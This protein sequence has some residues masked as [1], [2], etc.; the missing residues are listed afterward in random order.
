M[1]KSANQFLKLLLLIIF[2][3]ANVFAQFNSYGVK[4]GLQFNLLAPSNEFPLTKY[5]LNFSYLARGFI[6]FELSENFDA[7]AGLGYGL[8]S[9]DDYTGAHYNTTIIPLDV[10]LLYSP[11]NLDNW[12]PYLFGGLG[13]I[14]FS[15]DDKPVSPTIDPTEDSGLSGLIPV[16]IGTEVK[17]N[18]DMALDISAGYS[19]SFTDNL[20]FVNQAEFNDGYWHLGFGITFGGDNLDSDSD[21]DGLT[22]REEIEIGTN[23]EIADTDGDGLID[24]DE[25]RKHQTNPN[26]I[27]SDIDGLNDGEEVK[28]H[29]TNP[30]NADSD[31]DGLN[32]FDEV[33]KYTTNPNNPD[34][35]TDGLRD[36]DEVNN[37]KTKELKADSDSDGLTDGEEV[38]KYKTD[39]LNPDTDGGS[40]NDGEEIKR[41]TNPNDISDDVEVNNI[42]EQVYYENVYFSFD[43]H[44]LTNSAKEILDNVVKI[45]N[46]QLKITINLSA[47]TDNIGNE[48]Y[49]IK[50]SEKRAKT[51][52]KYLVENGLNESSIFYEFFGESKPEVENSSKQNRNKNRRVE[53]KITGIKK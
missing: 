49:N 24:G 29:Q 14:H 40:V 32:D 3:S 35:D 6:R 11:F 17:I 20:N 30:N 33:N 43:K 53:I 28:V 1:K 47:H 4:G 27:D 7:E 15:V 45:S 13:L 39:P 48:N 10:R 18:D 41:G 42:E 19:Y 22:K 50:L 9:G 36:G 51:V 37:Y 52:K 26:N 2:L 12:N 5:D 44:S 34:T 31:N 8:Y 46:N 16:G 38:N 25:F 21:K 23:H